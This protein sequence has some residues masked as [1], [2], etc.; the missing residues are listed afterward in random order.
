[1][2]SKATGCGLISTVFSSIVLLC[3]S[4]II[5]KIIV[6]FYFDHFEDLDGSI[7]Q[8]AYVI[9]VILCYF[10]LFYSRFRIQQGHFVRALHQQ[11]EAHRP[12]P[13]RG[14]DYFSKFTRCIFVVRLSNCCQYVA[15]KLC[16]PHLAK[17]LS[18]FLSIWYEIGFF[19][20]TVNSDRRF[21]AIT[22]PLAI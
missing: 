1:M 19:S 20:R 2:K 11:H 15:K 18:L 3:V 17:C 5:I 8:R 9:L 12:S 7:W 14:E 6:F 21:C 13:L 4:M 16:I 22:T 10:I